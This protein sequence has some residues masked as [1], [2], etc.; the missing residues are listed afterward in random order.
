M[1]KILKGAEPE[2][3]SNYRRINPNNNWDQFRQSKPRK[4]QTKAAI[5]EHQGG[6][7]AYCEIDLKLAPANA[8]EEDDFR[9]EHFH[10]KSDD[11]ESRNWSLDWH[12]LLG[13]CHGGSSREVTDA[14]NR[15]TSP[16]NS[17]DVP[18]GDN[19]WDDIILNPL[20]LP[21]F[22]VIFSFSRSDG[23]IRIIQEH[24]KT[25]HVD[26]TKAQQTVDKLL[27]DSNR[28]KRLRETVL[29]NINAQL[30][31]KVADGMS[32]A[33]ARTDLAQRLLRKDSNG[34]WPKFFSAIRYYLGDA[35][36]RQLES[37]HYNG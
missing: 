1:K 32:P 27:L 18:K 31:R 8:N 19:N 22:P 35:A 37:I 15:F 2:L 5:I 4:T 25:A 20:G 7:C 17:C 28:L 24:C 3:L 13:C 16:D 33:Q 10:P 9:V 6:L 36:E 29:N 14:A 34:C 12:N 26:E 30:Q 23:S 11:S 21:A